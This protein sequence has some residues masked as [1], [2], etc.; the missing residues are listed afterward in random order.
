[1]GHHMPLTPEILILPF[2]S[3]ETLSC[4]VP[5]SYIEN[6]M[7][8]ANS[9][10]QMQ[11]ILERKW[12]RFIPSNT[13]VELND[14]HKSVLIL[15]PH[16]FYSLHEGLPGSLPSVD[17]MFEEAGARY[18][19]AQ[20]LDEMGC[21]TFFMAGDKKLIDIYSRLVSDFK[22]MV[23]S[24]YFGSYDVA[25]KKQILDSFCTAAFGCGIEEFIKSGSGAKN[26]VVPGPGVLGVS[27]PNRHLIILKDPE[28]LV[29]GVSDKTREGLVKQHGNWETA[30]RYIKESAVQTT[31]AH[32]CVH[33]Y[34][35]RSHN[36]V[37]SGYSR[38]YAPTSSARSI[39]R[40][41]MAASTSSRLSPEFISNLSE[42]ATSL[43]R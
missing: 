18:Y 28:D 3:L 36:S 35:G 12:H 8:L 22:D 31:L 27:F 29:S 9:T 20:L 26:L 23:H 34:F 6:R 38:E 39:I 1:M 15:N 19:A 25:N 40:G 33:M 17:D 42:R 14:L 11:N 2:A 13:C 41:A 16:E 43:K 21:R 5:L 4:R 7:L 24:Q 37:S 10:R 30:K 32:E